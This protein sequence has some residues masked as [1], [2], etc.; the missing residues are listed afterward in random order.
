VLFPWL[1]GKC[2]GKTRKDGARTTLSVVW[3]LFVLF[4][5][6]FMC[7]CVLP[8]GD[9]PIA[10]NKYVNI[11]MK[12]I[13]VLKLV[14]VNIKFLLAV[15]TGVAGNIYFSLQICITSNIH[16]AHCKSDFWWD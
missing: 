2:Q 10:V 15:L 11:N 4:Y 3:L 12:Y 8:L 9:N 6:V 5:V 14:L 7:K 13:L 16:Y 1:Q